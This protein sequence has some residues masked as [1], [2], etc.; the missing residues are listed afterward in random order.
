MRY[1]RWAKTRRRY[2]YTTALVLL[3]LC[4]SLRPLQADSYDNAYDETFR[5]ASG[6]FTPQHDWHWLKAQCYQESLL[7]PRAVSSAG[8][9]GLCQFMPGT[10]SEVSERLR[11][12]ASPFNPR[13]NATAAAYYMGRLERQWFVKRSLREKQKL[14]QASYNAGLGNILK[15][16]RKCNDALLWNDIEPCLGY[17]ET[18]DYVTRIERWYVDMRTQEDARKTVT[19]SA[20]RPA[21]PEPH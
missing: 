16:Q 14:A 6:R 3:A 20:A 19:D 13:A 4:I 1:I 5:V 7:H 18:R 12:R 2:L 17:R 15:A 11:L 10:W 9:M 21:V 8:A